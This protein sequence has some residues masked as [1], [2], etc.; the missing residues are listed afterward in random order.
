MLLATEHPL[1]RRLDDA[2]MSSFTGSWRGCALPAKRAELVGMGWSA[3][4]RVDVVCEAETGP[5]SPARR[6][7]SRQQHRLHRFHRLAARRGKQKVSVAVGHTILVIAYHLLTRPDVYHELGRTYFDDHER[8]RVERR[9][10]TDSKL[11][12]TPWRSQGAA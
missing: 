10:S 9:S 7:G 12:A 1:M 5:R 4:K 3:A 6:N 2:W 8:A 11:S